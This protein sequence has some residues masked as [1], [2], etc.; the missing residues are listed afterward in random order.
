VTGRGKVLA[1]SYGAIEER[2][3]SAGQKYT[4]DTG[5]IVGFDST[6]GFQV[7]KVGGWKSTILSGEGLVVELTGPGRVLMQTRSEE[8]FI[9]WLG[10][11]LPR[12]SN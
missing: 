5:H 2:V 8:A 6:V 10:P 11:R 3:L 7:R 9:G 4:I 1:S 12:Q